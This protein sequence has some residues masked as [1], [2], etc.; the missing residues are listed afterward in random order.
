MQRQIRILKRAGRRSAFALM[1]AVF[2]MLLISIML[3]K[4]LSY[5][6]ENAQQVINE[7]LIEQAQLAAYGAT[8]YAMLQS[9]ADNRAAS[10]TKTINMTYPSAP[11]T[12]VFNIAV[13]M[14][15][16]WLATAIPP[17]TDCSN[18]AVTGSAVTV[19]TPEQNGSVY[20]DVIVTS[21]AALNLDEPIRF[22]RRTLQKL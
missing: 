2:L 1:A 9:A 5:S 12:P 3:L 14:Q 15:Y 21:N 11:N 18:T 19:S 8:E 16:V 22:H 20:V 7:Y 6:G 13:T 4:M 10:C 17:G